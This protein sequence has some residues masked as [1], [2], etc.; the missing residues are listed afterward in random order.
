MFSKAE[1]GSML[2]VSER[3]VERLIAAGRLGHYKTHPGRGGSVRVS[4]EAIEAFMNGNPPPDSR[5]HG[6]DHAA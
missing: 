1:A 5:E 4:P 6:A 3:T 2:G